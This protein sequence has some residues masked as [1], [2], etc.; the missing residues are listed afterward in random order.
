MGTATS[1]GGR[2]NPRQ[3]IAKKSLGGKRYQRRSALHRS[4]NQRRSPAV[5][6]EVREKFMKK[7]S[8]KKSEKALGKTATG[9]PGETID[10]EPNKPDM[11]GHQ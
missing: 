8:E 9:Q 2:H 6:E 7:L 10:T 1:L 5:Y 11:T 4:G 3:N